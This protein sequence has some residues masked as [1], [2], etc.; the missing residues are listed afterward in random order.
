MIWLPSGV[1]DDPHNLAWIDENEEETHSL[2]ALNYDILSNN[3]NILSK[4][5]DANGIVIIPEYWEEGKP[6]I[7][8]E[9]DRRVRAIFEQLYPEKEVV[10]INPNQQ[11]NK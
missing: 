9:K 5:R 11:S 8:K 7:V 2:H 6:E 10:G 4:H 3:Y 1:A